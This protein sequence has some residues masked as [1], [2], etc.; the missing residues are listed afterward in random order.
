M[1][2]MP[3]FALNHLFKAEPVLHDTDFFDLL[4]GDFQET[5]NVPRIAMQE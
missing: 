3:I 5:E 2:T 1:C 4:Q